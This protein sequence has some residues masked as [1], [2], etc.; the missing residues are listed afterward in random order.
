MFVCVI[1]L[2][3]FGVINKKEPFA[4]VCRCVSLPNVYAQTCHNCGEKNLELVIHE[5][6]GERI[7]FL[8]GGHVLHKCRPRAKWCIICDMSVIDNGKHDHA[9]FN[10]KRI[11]LDRFTNET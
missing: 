5:G 9:K 11:G 4:C 7:L 6:T 3:H 8:P 10:I 2:D 1:W